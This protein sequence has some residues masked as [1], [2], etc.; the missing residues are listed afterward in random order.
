M[1]LAENS[2]NSVITPTCIKEARK[3]GE[4]ITRIGPE[5]QVFL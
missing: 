5:L 3:V 4:K 2:K 1:P